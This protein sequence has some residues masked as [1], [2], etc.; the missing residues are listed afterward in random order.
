MAG[1]K[2]R[3]YYIVVAEINYYTTGLLCTR[4]TAAYANLPFSLRRTRLNIFAEPSFPA[5]VHVGGTL[6]RGASRCLQVTT[7]KNFCRM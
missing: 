5:A 7:F 3:A 4:L 2:R 6:D 1:N